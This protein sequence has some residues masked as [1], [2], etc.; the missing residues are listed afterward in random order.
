MRSEW[1]ER[2]LDILNA[3]VYEQEPKTM[4]PGAYL[5]FFRQIKELTQIELGRKLGGMS[6]QNVSDMENGRRPI[7]RMMAVRISRLFE[8][9]PDKFVG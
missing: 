8:V 1:G 9:S 5:R 4:N 2:K 7:S 6:R 3:P